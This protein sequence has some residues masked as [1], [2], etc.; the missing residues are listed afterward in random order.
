MYDERIHT[1]V[2]HAALVRHRDLETCTSHSRQLVKTAYVNRK[3]REGNR[4]PWGHGGQKQFTKVLH[5][6]RRVRRKPHLVLTKPTVLHP[7]EDVGAY[8]KKASESREKS[9]ERFSLGKVKWSPLPV[10]VAIPKRKSGSCVRAH[11]GVLLIA[12]TGGVLLNP[13]DRGSGRLLDSSEHTA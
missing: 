4:R 13:M 1:C 9:S 7:G 11:F 10:R 3:L 8:L 2:C 5:K 6:N 12:A